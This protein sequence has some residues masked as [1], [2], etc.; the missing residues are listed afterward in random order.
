MPSSEFGA[1]DVAVDIGNFILAV[2]GEHFEERRSRRRKRGDLFHGNDGPRR[3][4][5]VLK[6]HLVMSDRFERDAVLVLEGDAFGDEI[7]ACVSRKV[8][9]GIECVA[10][11]E[12]FPSESKD[13]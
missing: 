6:V 1:V 7:A 13:L 12:R 3:S 2:E 4:T 8:L 11:D 10:D 5:A 9:L